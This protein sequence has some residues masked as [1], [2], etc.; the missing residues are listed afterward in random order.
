MQRV[1]VQR[2]DDLPVGAHQFQLAK[3][4][5]MLHVAGFLAR[6]PASARAT[7]PQRFIGRCAGRQHGIDR[8][9][10][11]QTLQRADG[12]EDDEKITRSVA[13]QRVGRAHPHRLKL[14]GFIGHRCL[15][16]GH[17]GHQKGHVKAARQVAVGGPVGQHEDLGAAQR[18][19]A[20]VALRGE[21]GRRRL[22]VQRGNVG[23][24]R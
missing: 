2:V 1:P 19:A 22:A 11:L 8:G 5:F 3:R 17:A 9:V 21:T 16:W 6:Q 20:L 18:Q 4:R 23:G 12:G 7:G 13:R 24:G 10:G 15:A 14:L